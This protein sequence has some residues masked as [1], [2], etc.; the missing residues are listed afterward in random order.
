MRPKTAKIK[1]KK[2]KSKVKITF[3]ENFPSKR[4]IKMCVFKDDDKIVSKSCSFHKIII[5]EI[6]FFW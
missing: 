6:I 5:D 1:T 3:E 2:K 4:F